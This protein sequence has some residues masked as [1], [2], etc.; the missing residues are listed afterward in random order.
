MSVDMFQDL[1]IN[2]SIPGHGG[3][4]YPGTFVYLYHCACILRN[5]DIDGLICLYLNSKTTRS[6]SRIQTQNLTRPDLS[7]RQTD[8]SLR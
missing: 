2:L 5:W 3:N 7:H 1:H 6:K 4:K 8:G